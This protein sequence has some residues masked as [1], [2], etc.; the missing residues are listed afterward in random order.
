M[1][2]YTALKNYA[3]ELGCVCR[4]NEPMSAHTSF[5]IGGPADVFFEPA[6]EENLISLAAACHKWE[7]PLTVIGN[8]SNLLVSD[9]GIE[10]AVIHVGGG[11]AGYSMPHST[12]IVCGA[13]MKLSQLCNIALDHCLT[14]MEFAWGIP[15]TAGGAAYMNAGAYGSEMK[16]VLVSCRHVCADGS[17]GE[18]SGDELD[19][20]YR[21]SAYRDSGE[22][23]LSLK[24]KLE[25][26]NAN[27]IS[28]VM[29]DLLGRRKSKQPLEYPSAGSVFKRPTGNYAGTL[30]EKC[31]LKGHRIGGAQVSEKHAGFIVN[32]GGAACSDVKLL[33]EHIQRE[34][35]LQTSIKLEPEIRMIG[36]V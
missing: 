31:G 27:D 2:D 33:I 7:I 11:L 29:D 5:K 6:S 35:Y 23:I 14:G 8:G 21:H 32:C 12:E 3:A 36:R 1:T 18:R 16:Q 26:G 9:R 28:F 20:S 17:V 4:E 30:I 25:P 22:I 24:V 15:G 34:V 10:G 19:L 13:G